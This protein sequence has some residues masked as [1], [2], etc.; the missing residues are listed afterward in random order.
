[1]VGG[2][3]AVQVTLPALLGIRLVEDSGILLVSGDQ[4][5]PSGRRLLIDC[6]ERHRRRARTPSSA[7][8]YQAWEP[9]MHRQAV[10]REGMQWNATR[11]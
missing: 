6:L 2:T 9:W 3:V 11:G 8:R 1:M 7:K 4:E 10:A 5:A